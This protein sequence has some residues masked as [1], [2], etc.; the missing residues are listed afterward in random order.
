M[1]IT[2]KLFGSITTEMFTASCRYLKS[3]SNR[4]KAEFETAVIY[5]T[6]MVLEHGDVTH[7]NKILPTLEL[8]GLEPKFVRCVVPVIPFKYD[9]DTYQFAGTIN[10][11]KRRSMQAVDDDGIPKWENI[12]RALL[13]GEKPENKTAPAWKLETRMPG[14]L[15]SALKHGYTLAEIRAEFERDVKEL[16]VEVPSKAQAA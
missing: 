2:T 9:R 8:A 15:K 10:A 11:E 3:V 7:L 5:G 4:V 1:E 6:A 16:T 13:N 14:F 12:V